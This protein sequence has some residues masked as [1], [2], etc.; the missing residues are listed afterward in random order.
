M[1]RRATA[2]P[3]VTDGPTLTVLNGVHAAGKTTVGERLAGPDRPFHGETTDRLID[4]GYDSTALDEFQR[5]AFAH[6][7][8]RDRAFREAGRDV[9]VEQWH[10][11]NVAYSRN[12]PES[13]RIAAE[14]E[15]R[16]ADAL[17]AFDVSAV[18]LD[19][20]PDR[21]W[22][23]SDLFAPGNE[24]AQWFEATSGRTMPA[25]YRD[26][27]ASTRALYA[28]YGVDHRVVDAAG[29]PS[30]V[31]DRVASAVDDLGRDDTDAMAASDR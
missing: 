31:A 18:F 22:E 3:L 24:P 7:R 25:F 30:I 4:A 21:I 20:D 6:E 9:L 12:W 5:V 10:L 15:R 14:Q 11:G 8:A 13:D 16:L 19:L 28:E 23:R 27:A 1:N 2:A 29:E 26:V 17:D